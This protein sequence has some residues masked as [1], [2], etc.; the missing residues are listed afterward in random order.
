MPNNALSP[1]LLLSSFAS[2]SRNALLSGMHGFH[3]FA[4]IALWLAALFRF[5]QTLG[6]IISRKSLE[7][8]HSKM[9]N[10]WM[11]GL[12]EKSDVAGRAPF[13]IEPDTTS[14]LAESAA[15]RKRPANGVRR[16]HVVLLFCTRVFGVPWYYGSTNRS[17]GWSS[18]SDIR[19][20]I[21]R[22][23]K[24]C[25]KSNIGASLMFI[26]LTKVHWLTE[27]LRGFHN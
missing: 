21:A 9:H 25:Y 18:G 16:R 1:S 17:T 15:S 14:H 11:N 6:Q 20:G 12:G 4:Q 19:S 7:V 22:Q 2:V 13:N 26:S 3:N 8:P 24:V 27:R 5:R 10:H 23:N